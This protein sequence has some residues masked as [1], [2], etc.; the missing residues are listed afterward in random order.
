VRLSTTLQRG[1]ATLSISATVQEPTGEPAQAGPI[2][3]HSPSGEVHL[4]T[5]EVFIAAEALA[6]SYL[7]QRR[8]RATSPR[9]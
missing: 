6:I 7:R 3:A 4:S 9:G 1:D 5:V 8:S 2:V